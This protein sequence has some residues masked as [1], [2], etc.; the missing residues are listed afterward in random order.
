MTSRVVVS[1]RVPCSPIQAFEVF[2][3]EIG[4]WW[5][6]SG[7]FRFT[8]KGPGVM[9]IEPPGDDG[10]RGRLVEKHEGGKVF[11]IGDIRQWRPGELLVV[12]W[13]QA[14]FGPEHATEVE[15]RFEPVGPETRVTV[16]HRGWDSV[17]QSHVA[18]HG[19][20]LEFLY[21]HQGAQWRAGLERLRQMAASA[22]PSSSGA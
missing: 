4:E 17:P 21:Q 8:P 2:T 13:R 1:V 18:R 22:N 19:F 5:S 14:S 12:G 3:E 20:P 9:A 7:V 16:E 10:K 11:E 6:H 15:V